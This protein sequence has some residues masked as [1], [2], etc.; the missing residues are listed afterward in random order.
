MAK[1]PQGAEQLIRCLPFSTP[2]EA[3]DD[4]A[5]I[6]KSEDAMQHVIDFITN[7]RS[8][9]E[10]FLDCVS[11]YSISGPF[12]VWDS[13][14]YDGFKNTAIRFDLD[15]SLCGIP[16]TEASLKK[17]PLRVVDV[18][19]IQPGKTPHGAYVDL[20]LIFLSVLTLSTPVVRII[21]WL[22]NMECSSGTG[23]VI[24]NYTVVTAA[25][26]L[27][28]DSG[29]AVSVQVIAEEGRNIE[30][31]YCKL[32]KPFDTVQPIECQQCPITKENDAYTTI[33]G[34]PKDTS[35]FAPCGQLCM[36]ESPFHY[37]PTS[38]MIEH[39]G[40]T[41]EGNSGGPLIDSSGKVFALH[42]GCVHDKTKDMVNLA[43]MI[44]R[45]GNNIA[46][47]LQVLNGEQSI[48]S[49]TAPN[50]QSGNSIRLV[51]KAQGVDGLIFVWRDGEIRR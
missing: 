37:N 28:S 40:D 1:N 32:D 50:Q 46:A 16:I 25:H 22:S 47:L 24:D 34:F 51:R 21:A 41:E 13:Q 17:N 30:S 43:V 8:D 20:V 7:L 2:V 14:R 26:V 49:S 6:S 12:G 9:H 45:D 15:S 36:S 29:H 44:D 48:E 4:S 3:R 35:V 39:E 33:Y 31:R 5:S 11:I 38:K 18:E 42:S 23:T 19:E 27:V 10:N